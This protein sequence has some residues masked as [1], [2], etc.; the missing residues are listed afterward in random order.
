MASSTTP[1]E[2]TTRGRALRV[3]CSALGALC[4]LV[5]LGGCAAAANP[6]AIHGAHAGF[7]LGLWQGLIAPI[8]FLVSL[9]NHEVGIYEVHNSGAWY[10][11]GFLAGLSIFFSGPAGAGR[12]ARCA[13]VARGRAR[14]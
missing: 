9:F 3:T 10:D 14:T 2:L 4:L 13:R 7:W 12:R 6:D 11:F 1:M 5:V 8:A